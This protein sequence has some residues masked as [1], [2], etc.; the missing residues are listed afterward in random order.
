MEKSRESESETET[1]SESESESGFESNPHRVRVCPPPSSR[2]GQ[3]DNQLTSRAVMSAITYWGVKSDGFWVR[4]RVRLLSLSGPCLAKCLSKD[5]H[6]SSGGMGHSGSGQGLQGQVRPGQGL[7]SFGTGLDLHL[8]Y[9]AGQGLTHT[10][11]ECP[12]A[13]MM[14]IMGYKMSLSNRSL[15]GGKTTFQGGGGTEVKR[16][17]KGLSVDSWPMTSQGSRVAPFSDTMSS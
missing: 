8:G 3:D 12:N 5:F 10:S 11:P 13:R 4:V 14:M 17:S 7:G 9:V 2:T 1:E 6:M 16:F 15:F